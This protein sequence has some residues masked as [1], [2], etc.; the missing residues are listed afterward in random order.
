MNIEKKVA[1]SAH[2][3]AVVNSA[4]TPREM[5]RPR[6]LMIEMRRTSGRPMI[7]NTAEISI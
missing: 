4:A 6:I 7:P 1:N 5:Y 3:S 2:I